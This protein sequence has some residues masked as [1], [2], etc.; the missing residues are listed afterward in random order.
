MLG[1]FV[2]VPLAIVSHDPAY[3]VFMVGAALMPVCYL[4]GWAIPSRIKDF[5]QGPPLGELL[6]GGV[7]GAAAAVPILLMVQ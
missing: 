3:I 2:A 7:L 4:I 6:Y 1:T 5:E